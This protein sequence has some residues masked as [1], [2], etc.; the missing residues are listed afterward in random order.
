MLRKKKRRTEKFESNSWVPL[1]YLKGRE[2]TSNLC[3][4][5]RV[6]AHLQDKHNG[7]PDGASHTVISRLFGVK[8]DDSEY[9]EFGA[10]FATWMQ[11]WDC[12]DIKNTDLP[13]ALIVTYTTN[14]SKSRKIIT[15]FTLIEASGI[16][17]KILDC[18][19]SKEEPSETSCDMDHPDSIQHF[20]GL[21]LLGYVPESATR[22]VVIDFF[23]KDG[24]LAFIYFKLHQDRF[25]RWKT[26]KD[27]VKE[28]ATSD[29]H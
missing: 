18:A 2:D 27:F 21:G 15:E 24:K 11:K 23:V 10:A 6:E 26:F 9:I 12:V 20:K 29:I 5:A 25:N 1:D 4:T 3:F 17:T 22:P 28:I 13:L 16:N 8:R 19:S 14:I 7:F